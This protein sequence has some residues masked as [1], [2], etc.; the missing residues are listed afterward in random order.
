[1]AALI[2]DH[3]IIGDL[4]TA[5]LVST[6]GDIDWLCLPRFDSPSVFASLLDDER[7]GRFTVRCTGATRVKQM[8]LP[9]SNVLVTRFLGESVRRR[10]RRL[11]G[12][13]RAGVEQARRQPA[14]A[15]R[16]GGPRAGRRRDP[17]RTGLR[18]R[19][20]ADRGGDRRGLRCLLLL[21]PH[22]ARPSVHRAADRRRVR[23]R[24]PRR[25]SRRARAW[26]W[27]CPDGARRTR[28][29]WARSR[30][31]SPPRCSTGSGGSA[32]P[33]TSGRY[34]EMV[35]RSALTLKLLVYQPTGALVAAPTTSLP[36]AIGGTRNWDYRFTW[37]RDAAFTVYA[38]M[39]L[40]FT[41]E[42]GAFMS[43]LGA[44]CTEAPPETGLHIL[45]GIDGDVVG[46]ECDAGSPARVPGLA[47]G[48]DRERRRG[49]APA[50]HRGRGHGLA[51]PVR[52][53]RPTGLLRAVDGAVPPAR[54][55]GGAL[56]GARLRGLG[57]PRSQ[58]ALHVLDADDLGGLRTGR[59]ARPPPR[60]SRAR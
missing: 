15:P 27:R 33:A 46:T 21:P 39:R 26:R 23:G 41:E 3:G 57:G 31:C 5:A 43:W 54:L 47:S 16:A 10:G 4:H 44:R 45:Y 14:R 51:P 40:G 36:E 52:P 9:D 60:A 11:H 35:E 22:P 49:P 32:S 56:G 12:A 30:T 2:E 13:A 24:G 7:G 25:C 55:A 53:E 58:A 6:D 18:L 59:P 1:M 28:W 42:A 50:R 37:V 20:G 17:V 8:Y 29:R 34:R 48:A 19:A 38:L